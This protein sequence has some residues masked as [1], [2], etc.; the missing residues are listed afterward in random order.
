VALAHA[1]VRPLRIAH[2]ANR[3]AAEVGT[4][5][6]GQ[7]LGRGRLGNVRPPFG[8]QAGKVRTLG[9]SRPIGAARLQL[10]AGIDHAR[11]Q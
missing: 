8:I 6:P 5:Q 10:H 11:R 4:L 9:K 7:H 1:G 2:V 3:V